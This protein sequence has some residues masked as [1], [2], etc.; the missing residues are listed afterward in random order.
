MIRLYTIWEWGVNRRQK[1]C[2]IKMK[3]KEEGL[4]RHP[5]P[6]R[7]SKTMEMTMKARSFRISFSIGEL[8]KGKVAI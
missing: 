3:P 2:P 5:S 6:R 7:R 8:T 4:A 1:V